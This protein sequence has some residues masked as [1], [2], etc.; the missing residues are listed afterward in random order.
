M[1]KLILSTLTCSQNLSQRLN[2]MHLYLG[3]L[4]WAKVS[5][6]V[7]AR[8]AHKVSFRSNTVRV[9]NEVGWGKLDGGKLWECQKDTERPSLL[10]SPP[11]KTEK[12]SWHT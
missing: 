12:N 10:L 1:G 3:S 9:V 8:V 5:G 7:Q 6:K 2:Y 4:R 11:A